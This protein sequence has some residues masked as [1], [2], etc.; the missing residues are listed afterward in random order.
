RLIL[1]QNISVKHS[2]HTSSR[3]KNLGEV[4]E[5]LEEWRRVMEDRGL[6]ISR[7]KTEYL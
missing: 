6:K 3:Y 5:K 1:A 4:E 2:L 7:K